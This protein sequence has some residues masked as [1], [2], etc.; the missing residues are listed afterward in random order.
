MPLPLLKSFRGEESSQFSP[1]QSPIRK[2]TSNEGEQTLNPNSTKRMSI[3]SQK[4]FSY[5]SQQEDGELFAKC[6][7]L[8]FNFE[9]VFVTLS[10]ISPP[11]TEDVSGL[12]FTCLNTLISTDPTK[13]PPLYAIEL[14]N[15][16]KVLKQLDLKLSEDEICQLG[17]MTESLRFEMF[18]ELKPMKYDGKFLIYDRFLLVIRNAVLDPEE[19]KIIRQN[20]RTNPLRSPEEE[21]DKMMI[22][23]KQEIPNI[24]FTTAS[25]ENPDMKNN[26]FAFNS[27]SK[28]PHEERLS[29]LRLSSMTYYF[30]KQTRSPFELIIGYARV[31][32]EKEIFVDKYSFENDN[33]K[34]AEGDLIRS[35][36]RLKAQESI[37]KIELNF[38]KDSK[39]LH[40]AN[41]I[42]QNS[43]KRSF[44]FLFDEKG[45]EFKPI[46]FE[47]YETHVLQCPESDVI[48]GL[49]FSIIKNQ[50]KSF[51]GGLGISMVRKLVENKE[52]EE[53]MPLP[54]EAW[55]QGRFQLVVN[56]CVFCSKHQTTTWHE[57]ADFAE[58][59]NELTNK[60]KETFPNSEIIGNYD[61]PVV[62]AGF[63]VYIRGVGPINERD[64]EARFF[65][66]RKEEPLK[67][68][69]DNFQV[70]CAQ[71]Y[72]NLCL[73]IAG[74][75]DTFELEKAQDDFFK[76]FQAVMPKKWEYSHEF[77]ADIPP[78][79]E[80]IKKANAGLETG[81]D[82]ICKNWG[83]G[84]IYKFD[85]N[86]LAK[87]DMCE[88]HPGRYEFGSIHG[89]WPESW[90]CC[91][92]NWTAKGC[93]RGKHRGVANSKNLKLCL[94]HGLLN[95][96]KKKD[97]NLRPDSFCGKAFQDGDGTECR[98][99][100]GY[101]ILNKFTKDENWS[102]CNGPVGNCDPCFQSA[103]K[104]ADWP[105]EEAK[106]Y[107]VQKSVVNPGIIRDYKPEAF[108]KTAVWSGFFRKSEPYL[109]K[110]N[111]QK[112]KLQKEIETENEP[113][114]CLN[115]A[116]EKVFKQIENKKTKTCRYHP[117]VWDFG[118][119]GITVSQAI[120][121]Y[122]K[123]DSQNILWKPHWTCCRK[124]W[125]SR[126]CTRGKHR[127]PLVAEMTER[128]FKWPTEHAQKYFSKKVSPFWFE[129]INN[130]H[131]YDPE[132][133]MIEWDKCVKL[134]GSGGV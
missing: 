40:S 123:K 91:R 88:Y 26:D 28:L 86:P 90:T 68:F 121:E 64:N 18:P 56:H 103:H 111:Q 101:I 39:F 37:S 67:E 44:V 8:A 75:G 31:F 83:C 93:K 19:I 97:Q 5:L 106:I 16:T 85:E 20:Y 124:P 24:A 95:P 112:M 104:S 105:S 113:R 80:K 126:G 45:M 46:P 110:A 29:E 132:R 69:K 3:L 131:R 41:F 129:K 82:M 108:S 51:L 127:G 130:E 119:S 4:L 15:F 98:F 48:I 1:P 63:E 125:E 96:I 77:P 107:F 27:L 74:Y 32:E 58:K 7:E 43:G 81:M 30:N 118:H 50:D 94:N 70:R 22:E 61:E 120:D 76:R 49:L 115:W 99:H 23:E 134:I 35:E 34:F 38:T 92:G 9:W 57:E 60:I 2:P 33:E 66:F 109:S 78:R 62:Y 122:F 117:G 13:P 47:G 59:F 128:R 65:L 84:K 11:L 102:C 6:R 25:P 89:L 52:D 12:P 71:I 116:C 10:M 54:A 21:N 100:Q 73:L 87:Q 17:K 133:M 114:Y 36:L 14:R 55:N 72:Q 79:S 42:L 53:Q